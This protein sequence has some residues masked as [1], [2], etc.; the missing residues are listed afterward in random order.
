MP[1]QPKNA[2]VWSEIHVRDLDAASAFYAKVTGME[3]QRMEMF[4]ADVAVFGTMDGSGFDLQVGEPGAGSV[5][6]IAAEGKL[7]DTMARVRE[8][9]GDVLSEAMQIPSGAFFACKDPDGNTV[10]FFEAA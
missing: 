6:Y 2:V 4:G 10:G 8:A 3:A 5:T 1:Y 9:G 7:A